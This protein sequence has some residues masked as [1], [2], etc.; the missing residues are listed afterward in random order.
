MQVFSPQDQAAVAYIGGVFKCERVLDEF[1]RR[2]ERGGNTTVQAPAFGPAAGALLEAYR[3]AGLQ[4][5]LSQVP[6]EK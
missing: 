6:P 3:T 5:T 4:V 1:R 2:L